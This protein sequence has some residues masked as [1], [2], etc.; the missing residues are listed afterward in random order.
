MVLIHLAAAF[1]PSRFAWGVHA[2][3]FFPLY[4][5]ITLPALAIV[6]VAAS[7]W[8]VAKGSCGFHM[9]QA[10]FFR[11]V[12]F[13]AAAL[14]AFAL[15]WLLRVKTHFL[16][17][18]YFVLR[19]LEQQSP[20]RYAEP[21]DDLMHKALYWVLGGKGPAAA[22][23]AYAL[24]SAL[25]GA[26][27][28]YITLVFAAAIGRSMWGRILFAATLAT[29]G[30]MQLFFGYAENYTL[31]HLGI[32]IYLYAAYLFHEG[33]CSIVV[34]SILLCLCIASHVAALSLVP[35]LLF[36]VVRRTEKA[37]PGRIVKRLLLAAI[38]PLCLA[39]LFPQAAL[40]LVSHGAARSGST[41]L[42]LFSGDYAVFSG[43][44]L[45]D[46]LNQ[47][48]LAAP[49]PVLLIA[50]LAGACG[51]R[52]L[53]G[54]R[55]ALFLSCA[56]ICTLG[57]TFIFNPEVGMSRDWD[58]MSFP[59]VVVAVWAAYLAAALRGENAAIQR[60]VT[61]CAALLVLHTVP[62]IFLNASRERSLARF[63]YLVRS[64][65]VRNPHYAHE[66]LAIYFRERN[67]H[68]RA[69][70]HYEKALRI[71]PD[72]ERFMLS[73]AYLHSRK[74]EYARAIEYC[75]KAIALKPDY[76]PAYLN[77]AAAYTDAGRHDNA[78][79]LLTRVISFNPSFGKAY[80]ALAKVYERAG[81]HDEAEKVRK[82]AAAMR[83]PHAR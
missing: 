54:D 28:V 27:Y 55:F 29:T 50:A 62:W 78:I 43:A 16:G 49:W 70:A 38:A 25:C 34:P 35:S 74:K 61:L 24:A 2:L 66:E 36:L 58:L 73:L 30:A 65:S 56:A 32:L 71:K 79:A 39:A 41:F 67:E 83:K 42:P 13:A 57:F 63:E 37:A 40:R 18:G 26:G 69:I 44:H 4:C 10:M 68:T 53:Y 72:N 47:Q 64:G 14:V 9:R 20:L 77:L 3:S 23:S 52:R 60:M 1:I 5:R 33:R 46:F 51:I 8:Y 31:L 76:A 45:L 22:E 75:E 80:T 17:D 82:K 7:H 21:L 48:L 59:A 19:C 6:I 12:L 15:F 81:Q 11:H